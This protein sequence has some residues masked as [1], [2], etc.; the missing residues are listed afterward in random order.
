MSRLALVHGFLGSAANWGPVLHKLKQRPELVG[1][2]FA[3]FDLLGHGSRRDAARPLDLESIARDLKEQIGDDPVVALGHSFGV[4]PLL[5][6]A[7]MAPGII[8]HLLVEDSSPVL[9]AAG[10]AELREIFEVPTPFETR[11]AAR[12]ALD[13]R[14]GVGSRLSRFLLSNIRDFEGRHD[15]RFDHRLRDLLEASAR[16]PLWSA[17]ENFEGEIHMILGDRSSFVTEERAAECKS[18]RASRFTEIYRLPNAGH[19]VHADDP[20]GFCKLTSQ[21]LISLENR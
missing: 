14:F 7:E 16:E 17:W 19:W 1:W 4:R 8:T 2:D 15:W 20:D 13:S 3:A 12:D 18:R 6:I 10:L 5:K 21:I 11:E 9:S